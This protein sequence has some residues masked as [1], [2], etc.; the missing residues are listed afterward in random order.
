VGGKTGG[1]CAHS[2]YRGTR[3]VYAAVDVEDIPVDL[4]RSRARE[5]PDRLGGSSGN[6]DASLVRPT[7]ELLQVVS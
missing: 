4:S 7:V 2:H 3:R 6:V 5:E 1:S